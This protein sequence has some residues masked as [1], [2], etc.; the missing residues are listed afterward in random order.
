[1]EVV[2]D[3]AVMGLDTQF[4]AVL[5]GALVVEPVPVFRTVLVVR[6]LLVIVAVFCAGV[7]V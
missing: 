5:V 6:G 1:M 2:V 7:L 4:V 3:E